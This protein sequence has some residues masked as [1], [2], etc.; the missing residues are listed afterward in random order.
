MDLIRTAYGL[1]GVWD[2]SWLNLFLGMLYSSL[3][4]PFIKPRCYLCYVHARR[5]LDLL[6]T[7][8]VSLLLILPEAVITFI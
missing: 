1:L 2:R 6:L 4:E 3:P 8:I 5:Q 7:V